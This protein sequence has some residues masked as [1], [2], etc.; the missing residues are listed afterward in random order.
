MLRGRMIATIGQ[1]A[2][3]PREMFTRNHQEPPCL[4]GTEAGLQLIEYTPVGHLAG[5]FTARIGF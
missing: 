5:C 2:Y 4:L 1:A 3:D